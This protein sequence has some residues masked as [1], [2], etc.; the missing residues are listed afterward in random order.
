M[1]QQNLSGTTTSLLRTFTLYKNSTDFSL[2]IENQFAFQK[3]KTKYLLLLAGSNQ[4]KNYLLTFK[5]LTTKKHV[6]NHMYSGRL[7]ERGGILVQVSLISFSEYHNFTKTFTSKILQKRN[8]NKIIRNSFP[9]LLFSNNNLNTSYYL[10]ELTL[11]FLN[12]S[13]DVLFVSTFNNNWD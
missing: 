3:K 7:R 10:N 1:K 2:N 12:V 11:N 4:T 13:K 6:K 5:K 8:N 9:Q